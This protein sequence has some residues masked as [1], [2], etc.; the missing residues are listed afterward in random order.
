M[1]IIFNVYILF[2]Q[3]NQN[4]II[5]TPIHI[6]FPKTENTTINDVMISFS[7]Y[8]IKMVI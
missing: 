3:Y 7:F 8:Y 5:I 4:K 6:S 1:E 2:G